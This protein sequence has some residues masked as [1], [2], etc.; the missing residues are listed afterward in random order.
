MLLEEQWHN[1]TG[2]YE[3]SLLLPLLISR[4]SVLFQGLGNATENDAKTL[5]FVSKTEG[6]HTK[7][8][9]HC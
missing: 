9:F 7:I 2:H 1:T 6:L 5:E 3:V 8:Y 4:A